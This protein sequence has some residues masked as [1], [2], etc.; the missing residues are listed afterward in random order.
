MF[1]TDLELTNFRNYPEVSIGLTSGVTVFVGANGQGKTNLVEAIEYLSTATSHRVSSVVPLIRSGQDSAIVR[2]RIQAGADDARQIL[3]ELEINSGRA[4]QA[5]LNR[6]PL[7]R[8][9][10]LVGMCRTVVFSP[11]DLA[12]VRGDPADRRRWIDSLV[13]TRWPRMA[14]VR[15]DLDRVLKQ[16]NALLK[17]MSTRGE[18]DELSLTVWN[19]QFASIAAELLHA[20]LDTLA[21]VRPFAAAAYETIAPV[22][23]VITA[24]YRT[25]I[26]LLGVAGS[27]DVRGLLRTRLLEAMTEA[28]VEE[29][30]RGVTLVGPQRDDI[31]LCIGPLPAKGYASHGESWSLALAL[32]LG[33]FELVRADG[34]E[35]VLVLDDVFAELDTSRRQRLAEAVGHAEQVLITAAVGAD[36]PD[37]PAQRRFRV[38]Q[39]SVVPEEES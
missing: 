30:R 4:N 33:G 6:A 15:Q 39:G 21:D 7:P 14:G 29:I 37:F 18:E 16:R 13:T 11:M 22:N 35:P 20:R 10:D 19:E 2:A 8:P 23:N 28:R 3:L 34:I 9:R 24:T 25:G 5:R 32:R 36:V 27:D 17:A 31:D 26:D 12:I 38:W 1:V